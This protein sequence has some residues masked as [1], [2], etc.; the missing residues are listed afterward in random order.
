[1]HMSPYKNLLDDTL[2]AITSFGSPVFYILIIL[3][4]LKFNVSLAM[5]LLGALIFVELFCVIIKIIYRKERPVEQ[6]RDNIYNKI[7]ANSFPS[8][9]SAR[10]SLIAVMFSL[11]YKDAPTIIAC[12]LV[13]LCVGYSRIYLKRHHPTDVLAGFLIGAAT[14]LIVFYIIK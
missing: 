4:L 13:V 6:A 12:V 3:V 14:A 5:P 9:H 11:F 10:I 7:D 8:I 1:M 2:G